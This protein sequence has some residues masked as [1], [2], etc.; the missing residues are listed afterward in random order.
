M[1]EKM[2]PSHELMLRVR[3]A[4]MAH[5][6]DGMSM[7]TLAKACGFTR[8]SLYNYFSNKEEAFRAM[9]AYGNR[10]HIRDGLAAGAEVRRRGGSALDVLAEILDVRYGMTR[11]LV[12]NSP[13]SIEMNA[14]AYR[15]CRDLMIETALEFQAELER[16]LLD[17]QRDGLIRLNGDV[18]A[19]QVAQMLADSGRA[20]N[21]ALPPVENEDFT[22][23]YRAMCNAVLYGSASVPAA[24]SKRSAS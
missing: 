3:D 23:R 15:R 5:G 8:R 11:R 2:T 16:L 24:R 13:H 10:D 1:S 6:Y 14:E 18:S 19:K 12:N 21:Q 9:I 20:V 22:A 7:V 4:F 17:L